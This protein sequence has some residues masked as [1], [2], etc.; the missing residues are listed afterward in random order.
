MPRLDQRARRARAGFSIIEVII[1]MVVLAV[2]VLGLAGTT[3][4]IVRQITLGDLMTE[5]S[6]AFQTVIDRL[7]AMPYA[8]VT[9]GMDSVGIFEVTWDAVDA[10][11]QNKIVTV[12]TKGPGLG[13][14]AFPTN[15]PQAVDTFVFR[16]LRR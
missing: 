7:Q 6:V 5:R 10:G 16:V 1:A 2:G 12:V 14:T 13:G 4:Y 11:S 8:N 3:A 9:T 15:N